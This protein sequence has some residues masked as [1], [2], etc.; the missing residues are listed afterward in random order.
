[1]HTIVLID[2]RL[3]SSYS[4]QP[5]GDYSSCLHAIQDKARQISDHIMLLGHKRDIN[6]DDHASAAQLHAA[7]AQHIPNDAT[8][9]YLQGDEPFIDL[10]LMRKMLE[11]HHQYRADLT[12]AQGYPSG[13]TGQIIKASA[14]SLMTPLADANQSTHRYQFFD[15]IKKD[16][17]HFDIETE[18]SPIDLRALRVHLDYSQKNHTLICQQIIQLGGYDTSSILPIIQNHP[19]ALWS[20][21]SYYNIQISSDCPQSCSYCPYPRHALFGQ[22]RFMSLDQLKDLVDQIVALSDTAVVSLS[23]MGESSLHPQFVQAMALVLAQPSLTLHIETSGLGWTAQALDFLANTPHHRFHLILSLDSLKEHT[24]AQTR[25]EGFDSV[26]TFLKYCQQHLALSTWVQTVRLKALEN[27]LEEFYRHFNQ[28]NQQVIIQK[29]TDFLQALPMENLADIA[30]LHRNVCWALQREMTIMVDG[31]ILL[32]RCALSPTLSIGDIA[33]EGLEQI[34][35][36]MNPYRLAHA[37]KK[38]P[39]PCEKCDEYYVFNF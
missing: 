27:E 31:Q 28:E 22:H 26:M 4:L 24:Y 2:T 37:Q 10:A 13:L 21:P 1:M 14:L 20:V 35:Q 15:T 19:E 18:I 5:W 29:Y 34:W 30:P 32:C 6:I 7:L 3:Q 33:S 36:T 25:G 39:Q 12:F 38:Y 16:I 23:Y 8:L 17:N 11:H 9:I